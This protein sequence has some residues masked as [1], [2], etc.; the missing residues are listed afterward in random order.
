M[1]QENYA[2]FSCIKDLVLKIILITRVIFRLKLLAHCSREIFRLQT[3]RLGR[4][5]KK[6]ILIKELEIKLKHEE[7]F[8]IKH[9]NALQND[10]QL[11]DNN[12]TKLAPICNKH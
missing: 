7:N 11:N 4:N 1:M 9:V 3:N 10:F 2:S 5:K 8:A 6:V 12:Y